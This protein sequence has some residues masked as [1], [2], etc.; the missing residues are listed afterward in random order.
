MKLSKETLT[1]IKN[2]ASIN[3]N[4]LLKPGKRLS[5][6]LPG[7][8]IVSMA[9]IAEDFP[10]EF[11][12]Y[13]VNEFLSIYSLF[14]D[15]DLDFQ[16]KVVT[17]REGNSSVKY[18][19]AAQNLVLAP[20][21]EAN[22]GD[23]IAAFDLSASL[24]NTI[25]KTAPT[26]KVQNVSVVGDGATLSIVVADKKNATSPAYSTTVG[27]TT[28]SFRANLNVDNLKMLG[29]DYEVAISRRGVRFQAKAS[30]LVYY[31]AIELDSTFPEAE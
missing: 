9:S 22:L 25:L 13:D 20:T 24:L 5:T 2:Y 27:T 31:V 10:V 6:I 14:N 29:G 8:R 30:D 23:V 3:P 17:I 11:P 4:L 7:P 1:L 15:P 26:L 12:I 18:Y 19:A 28:Q 21:K 16:D